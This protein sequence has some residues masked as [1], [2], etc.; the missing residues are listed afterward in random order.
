MYF[1]RRFI[2]FRSW[3]YK[4]VFKISEFG[5]LQKKSSDLE[6]SDWF[7]WLQTCDRD[8]TTPRS[9]QVIILVPIRCSSIWKKYDKSKRCWD[10]LRTSFKIVS[11]IWDVVSSMWNAKFWC[12]ALVTRFS[13]VA[14]NKNAGWKWNK[15]RCRKRKR[16]HDGMTCDTW[17][18][19]SQ[20][21]GLLFRPKYNESKQMEN[22]ELSAK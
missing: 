21:R 20:K 9:V 1:N 19:L 18:F 15:K 16:R 7:L 4:K 8:T 6:T 13:A 11:G 17:I 14:K 22:T 2:D 12:F 10:K 3:S 5:W